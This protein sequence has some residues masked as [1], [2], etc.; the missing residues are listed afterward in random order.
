MT[1]A[2]Y[3]NGLDNTVP[4][5]LDA[6]NI[7]LQV[8]NGTATQSGVIKETG[9]SFGFAKIGVGTLVLSAVNTYT[10]TSTVDDGTLLVTG[11]VVAPTAV[12]SGGTLAG[13]GTVDAISV[14]SGGKLAPGDSSGDGSFATGDI[15]LVSGAGFYV[16]LGFSE[17]YTYGQANTTGTVQ[18]GGSTLYTTLNTAPEITQV[19]TIIVND[20]TDKVEGQFKPYYS[21]NL[22]T[23]DGYGTT[24]D[25]TGGDGNDVVLTIFSKDVTDGTNTIDIVDADTTV[26][27]EPLPTSRPDLIFGNGGDDR[28]SSLGGRDFVHGG[29]DND[30]I[31][32]GAGSDILKGGR[33]VDRLEGGKGGDVLE[34][35]KAADM[36]FGGDGVDTFVFRHCI[37]ADRVV[38]YQPGEQIQLAKTAF[39]GIGPAGVLKAKF[40][41]LGAE[42]ETSDQHI[43]YDA[44]TGWLLYARRGSGTEDPKAFAWIGAGLDDFDRQ[45]ILVI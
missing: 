39:A 2:N 9:G 4:I 3:T 19:I 30:L 37:Y 44:A 11:T 43:L 12:A 34:S 32:G 40:F 16:T 25:Y 24:I 27:G 42:A 41:H 26:D 10:G 33:G 21:D 38:D 13:T 8:N 28:L 7:S 6:D 36:L 18:L 5:T 29:A 45:D 15:A 23:V 35:G 14:A 17:H 1:T 22:V 31:R 20:G